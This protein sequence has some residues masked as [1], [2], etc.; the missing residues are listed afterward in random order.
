MDII[1]TILAEGTIIIF[2]ILCAGSFDDHRN[3]RCT[4]GVPASRT[5]V[6]STYRSREDGL[7]DVCVTVTSMMTPAQL[8]ANDPI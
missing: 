5:L 1:S 7:T 6:D 8:S 2:R 4:R 3:L